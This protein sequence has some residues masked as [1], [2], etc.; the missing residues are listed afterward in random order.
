M[1]KRFDVFDKTQVRESQ[2]TDKRMLKFFILLLLKSENSNLL[3][4][5]HRHANPQCWLLCSKIVLTI[6]PK[7]HLSTV[8]L[9]VL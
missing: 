7:I 2:I 6:V 4:T 3:C 5:N 1:L 9:V 8:L